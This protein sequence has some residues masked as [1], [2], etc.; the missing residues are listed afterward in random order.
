MYLKKPVAHETRLFLS[1]SF[2]GY[3]DATNYVCCAPTDATVI[4]T[5]IQT[6]S[7]EL[8]KPGVC[9]FSLQDKIYGGTKSKI[10]D[11]PWL[12]LLE[13]SFSSGGKG[14]RCGGKL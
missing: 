14:F 12:V 10:T 4:V 1:K 3:K 9:G 5:K 2:C 6:K 11:F 7:S 13:Y 8:P